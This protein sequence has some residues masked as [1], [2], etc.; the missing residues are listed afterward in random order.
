MY[1]ISRTFLRL[2]AYCI[3]RLENYFFQL[4]AGDPNIFSNFWIWR[5]RVSPTNAEISPESQSKPT[6][7]SHQ[8]FGHLSSFDFQLLNSWKTVILSFNTFESRVQNSN[9]TL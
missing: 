4:V 1:A 9:L 6:L 3:P 8:L 7:P 5:W 2:T